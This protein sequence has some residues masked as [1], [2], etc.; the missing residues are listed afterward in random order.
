MLAIGHVFSSLIYLLDMAC[1]LLLFITT[2]K[3]GY[4]FV[5]YLFLSFQRFLSFFSILVLHVS[6]SWCLF[7]IGISSQFD[8]CSRGIYDLFDF[9]FHQKY[10]RNSIHASHN[11][12][13]FLL[14]FVA[15]QFVLIFYFGLV[16]HEIRLLVCSTSGYYSLQMIL[17]TI[18]GLHFIYRKRLQWM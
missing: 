18:M 11:H 16:I 5:L 12:F 6:L 8:V 10:H 13:F 3:N 17:A 15:S 1:E 9:C 2:S 7:L 14:F 4:L